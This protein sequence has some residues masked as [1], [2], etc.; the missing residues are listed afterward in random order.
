MEPWGDD[1]WSK[2][3]FRPK[4]ATRRVDR[5]ETSSASVPQHL[6]DPRISDPHFAPVANLNS[7]SRSGECFA[8][9][10]H[11]W[12]CRPDVCTLYGHIIACKEKFMQSKVVFSIFAA[13]RRVRKQICGAVVMERSSRQSCRIRAQVLPTRSICA[14]TQLQL[15]AFRLAAL[16]CCVLGTLPL[17]KAG[18]VA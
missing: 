4:E 17:G 1:D 15:Q 16:W 10:D 9:R 11:T 5:V 6:R 3:Q 13:V 18:P 7:P 2:T 12:L 8:R 14:H